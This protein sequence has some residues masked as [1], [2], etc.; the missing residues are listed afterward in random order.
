MKGA[1]STLPG[2]TATPWFG[3]GD[4]TAMQ[5]DYESRIS[6]KSGDLAVVVAR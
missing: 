3:S 1:E 5:G 2:H 4:G 6:I